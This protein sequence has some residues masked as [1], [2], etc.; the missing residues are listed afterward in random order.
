MMSEYF[1]HYLIQIDYF[2]A[3]LLVL[4]PGLCCLLVPQASVFQ[5]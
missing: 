4:H 5:M 3:H 2:K 1:F